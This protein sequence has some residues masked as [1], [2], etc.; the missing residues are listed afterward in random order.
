MDAPLRRFHESL[1]RV[2]KAIKYLT[3]MY[4]G[5]RGLGMSR[6]WVLMRLYNKGETNMSELQKYMFLSSATLTGLVDSLVDDDLVVRSRE[7]ADRRMVYLQLTR[8][9]DALC[10]E[11]LDYRCSC[12]RDTLPGSSADL[13]KTTELLNEIFNGL[14]TQIVSSA[15]HISRNCSNCS[16]GAK[17]G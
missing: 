1:D 13:E 16:N 5:K 8:A 7:G 11:V 17:E 10:K 14:K 4:L 6:Y 12:L 9:G 3:Q 15:E 2:N